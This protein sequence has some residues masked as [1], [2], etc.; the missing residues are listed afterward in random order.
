MSNHI[1]EP[2]MFDRFKYVDAPQT[3]GAATEGS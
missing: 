1:P 3:K 2:L